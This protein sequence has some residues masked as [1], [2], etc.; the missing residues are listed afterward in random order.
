MKKS[1]LFLL[2]TLMALI[3]CGTSAP[4][5]EAKE[6]DPFEGVVEDTL[7]HE[8]IFG[9]SEVG[10]K[11]EKEK[12]A[13]VF[14]SSVEPVIGVQTQIDK[15]DASKMHMRFVAAVKIDGELASATA[16]WTRAIFYDST[17]GGNASKAHKDY[18]A[19]TPKIS[20][21]AYTTLNNG[22]TEY[23]ISTFDSSHGSLGY[24]YF[25][26]YTV[27]NIPIAN[28]NYYITSYVSVTDS[29]GTVNSKVLATSVDQKTQFSYNLDKNNT[30]YFGVK[31][32]ISGGTTTFSTFD[33][34]SNA[35]NGNKARFVNISLNEGESF[36]LVNSAA[37]YFDVYGYDMTHAADNTDATFNYDD[38]DENLR[39]KFAVAKSTASHYLYLSNGGQTQNYIYRTDATKTK[40]FYLKPGSNWYQKDGSN[41]DPRFA[42]YDAA[43]YSK[44]YDMPYMVEN[45]GKCICDV[46]YDNISN[47][48]LIFCRMNSGTSDNNFNEGVRYNQTN[49][50]SSTDG[51]C[52][53]VA[54]G[55]WSYGDGEWST[56]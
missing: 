7:A 47:L 2:P 15:N 36:V 40:T 20:N 44:W 55:A 22:G 19:A 56:I 42:L 38:V 6:N 49:N 39:S 9:N 50:L 1:L 30:G 33:R 37:D 54:D 10:L 52:Y 4:K 24:N 8:E 41:R 21:K 13:P 35:L 5:I 23:N 43:S 17:G 18:K 29:E 25:V 12:K 53:T 11:L 51:N 27:L 45:N 26:V 46:T 32:V 28:A 48:N 14:L 16:V 31:R 34:D 3:A